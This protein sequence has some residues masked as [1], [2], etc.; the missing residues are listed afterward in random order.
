M[1]APPLPHPL[2]S[3]PHHRPHAPVAVAGP[4]VPALAPR[5]HAPLLPPVLLSRPPPVDALT[6]GSLAPLPRARLQHGHRGAH[7]GHVPPGAR[8]PLRPPRHAP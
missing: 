6:A 5:R 3:V 1:S 8:C 4:L 7:P 2:P